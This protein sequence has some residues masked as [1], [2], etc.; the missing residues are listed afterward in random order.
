VGGV[1]EIGF[2]VCAAIFASIWYKTYYKNVVARR[3][4]ADV[5]IQM[6]LDKEFELIDATADEYNQSPLG[7]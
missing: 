3:N 5:K 4:L 2:V 1:V 7:I 6:A